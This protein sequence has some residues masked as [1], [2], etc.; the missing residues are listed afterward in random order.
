MQFK[1]FLGN[2]AKTYLA[3]GA[4]SVS[5]SAVANDCYQDPCNPCG[6]WGCAPQHHCIEQ[7]VAPSCGWGYNPPAYL[8]CNNCCDP[9]ASS[10][11]NLRFRA[12]FLWWR[13]SEEGLD[14][15]HFNNLETYDFDDEDGFA[16]YDRSHGKHIDPRYEP[17]FRIGLASVCP[18]DCGW[19]IALNWTHFHTK[20]YAK[21][22]ADDKEDTYFV[23]NWERFTDL[24]TSEAKARWNLDL[25]LLDLEF[26]RKFYVASCFVLRP[27]FG[28]RGARVDQSYRVRS[29]GTI[30]ESLTE[31]EEN[32]EAHVRAKNNFLAVGPRVGAYIEL[33]FGCGFSLFGDGAASILFGKADVH[34]REILESFSDDIYLGYEEKASPARVSRAV[35]DLAF[36]IK[37]D[38][39]CEWCNHCHPVSLAVAWEHHGFWDFNQFNFGAY[40]QSGNYAT[41]GELTGRESCGKSGNLFTQGLTLTAVIGF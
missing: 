39:L 8:T 34:S 33:D 35:T 29:F 27:Y 6:N 20:G 37:W 1:R 2:I 3:I 16:A 19:D 26:A 12:D 22:F 36:G 25:D 23:S 14:L 24:N 4:L 15:G 7:P 32:Y 30:A 11:D 9:C 40:G 41:P 31:L 5:A 21:A 13:A 38:H 18:C 10:L 17:G 28:L